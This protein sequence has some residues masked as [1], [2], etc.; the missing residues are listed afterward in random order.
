MEKQLLNTFQSLAGTHP[1]GRMFACVFITRWLLL[2]DGSIFLFYLE[3]KFKDS[4]KPI[5]VRGYE[6][7]H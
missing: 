5:G 4:K 2:K 1:E 7:S 6:C 3:S